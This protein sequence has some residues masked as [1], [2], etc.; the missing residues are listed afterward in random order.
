[1]KVNHSQCYDYIILTVRPWLY[2]TCAEYGWYQTSGSDMQI[3][4]S[5]FPVDLYIK[6]CTDLYDYLLVSILLFHLSRRSLRIYFN[7]LRFYQTRMEAN[8]ERT[9]TIYGHMNPAVTN[10]FFTQGQLDPWRPMGLQE[11]LNEHSPAV[12]IPS[13]YQYS[14]EINVK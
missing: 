8:I 1:M 7:S 5:G 4:G 10:I 9:N 13:N 3:F 6:M 14:L 12:V 11:D 2:Q